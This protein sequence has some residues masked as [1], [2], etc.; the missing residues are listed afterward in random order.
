MAFSTSV[1][2]LSS[3]ST[4]E[5]A[6]KRFEKTKRPISRGV[7]KWGPGERPLDDAKKWHY[8][9]ERGTDASYYDV[10][11]YQTVMARFHK[12]EADGSYCCEYTADESP[13]SKQFM[14]RVTNSQE[15]MTRLDTHGVT[16][17]IPV[18]RNRNRLTTKLWF[19]AAGRLIVER[20]VHADCFKKETHPEY[21]AWRKAVRDAQAPLTELM[22]AAVESG[23]AP[24]MNSI[25]CEYTIR[26]EDFTRP[27]DAL[28]PKTIEALRDLWLYHASQKGADKTKTRA[29]VMGVLYLL[30]HPGCIPKEKLTPIEPFPT[31][32][33]AKWTC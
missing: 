2:N 10:C 21:T 22:W 26:W 15:L 27:I 17:Y 32:M 14:W 3:C 19:N 8:R 20:S 6:H 12:P 4:Y 5:A 1:H 9:I 16:R 30:T 7:Q 11:L 31:E 33:P 18:A 23:A 28:Q 25:D 24:T 13:M 29:A